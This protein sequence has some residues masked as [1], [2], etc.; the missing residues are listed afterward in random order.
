MNIPKIN[1]FT[2]LTVTSFSFFLRYDIRLYIIIC[3]KSIDVT[4]D[5]ESDHSAVN[6]DR[7][8]GLVAKASAS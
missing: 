2:S 6:C 7:H 5:I 4:N 8:G 1:V 3:I